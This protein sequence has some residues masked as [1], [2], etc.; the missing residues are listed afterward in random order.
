[1]P[2]FDVVS[3]FDIQEVENSVNM[4]NRDIINRY[5]FKGSNTNITLNK[6]EPIIIPTTVHAEIS[7]GRIAR[8]LISEPK[9][10]AKAR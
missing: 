10:I 9:I 5:D 2:S 1:M 6:K 8:P 4:V 7:T 3:K